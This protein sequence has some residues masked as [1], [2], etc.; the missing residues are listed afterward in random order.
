MR[1]RSLTLFRILIFLTIITLLASSSPVSGSR[2][3]SSSVYLPLVS[4][5]YEYL[6]PII[7]DTTIVLT[8][9]STSKIS[10][11]SENGSIFTFAMM[12]PELEQV[13]VGDV[14]ISGISIAAPYGFMRK[15]THKQNQGNGLILTTEQATIEDAFKQVFVDIQQT[16]SSEDIQSFINIPGI[17]LIKTPNAGNIGDFQFE[18]N[19]A[20]LYDKDNDLS[21]TDDQVVADGQLVFSPNYNFRLKVA[22]FKVKEIY[23]SQTYSFQTGLTVSSKLSLTIPAYEK[24]LTPSFPLAAFPIPG[25]PLVVT[26][27][28]QIWTGINGNVY[29]GVSS[30]VTQT[31][32]FTAGLQY[33]NNTW[34]PI[35]GF[36]NEFMFNQ[37][38]FT[39]GV[40]FKAYVGPKLSFLLNGVV[41]PYLKANL[42]LK[43]DIIPFGNPWLTLQGGLEVPIGVNVEIFSHVLLDYQTIAIDYWRLLYSL[44]SSPPTDTATPTRTNTPTPTRTMTPTPT[45]NPTPTPTRTNTPTPTLTQQPS[46][47]GP[48]IFDTVDLFDDNSDQFAS[49]GW[50]VGVELFVQNLGNSSATNVCGS[51]STSDPY[52]TVNP[53]WDYD[54]SPG[55]LPGGETTG[56]DFA[57]DVDPNT[58][59]GHT[60]GFDLDLFAD[61]GGPWYD[62]FDVQVDCNPSYIQNLQFKV[63]FQGRSNSEGKPQNVPIMVQI[64]SSSGSQVLY[65]SSW[66]SVTPAGSSNNWGT[67][68]IDVSSANLIPGQTYQIKTRGAMHLRKLVTIPLTDGMTIDYTNSTLNPN[69]ILWAGDVNQDNQIDINDLDVISLHFGNVVPSTPDPYSEIYRSDLNGDQVIDLSDL[70]IC[71]TN[72]GKVGD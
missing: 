6:P 17:S 50:S 52:I 42:G 65:N 1:N 13:D 54:C 51:L 4:R 62:N 72:S 37:P 53:D 29:A 33:S 35:I 28:L 22:N 2:S 64:L 21:T 10:S 15:V 25:L 46:S 31:T 47:V 57:F 16:L 70:V 40:S 26:P 59:D 56:L 68:T 36:T 48:I 14:I 18:L 27:K 20:V 45:N 67:A 58:P 49:C 24:P 41:G 43:L 55:D 19:N 8:T 9:Q 61:N 5:D 30:S 7:A 11:I 3:T 12:T 63:S 32:S 60:I 39:S 34:Q 23:F 38:Q 71:S 66:V 44:S 69:Q